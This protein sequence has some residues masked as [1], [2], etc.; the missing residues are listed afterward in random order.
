[1]TFSLK[2]RSLRA[3]SAIAAL[4]AFA[5]TAA[6]ADPD[7]NPLSPES[8]TYRT[9]NG[10]LIELTALAD[11]AV[12]V[13]YTPN[14][15]FSKKP[16]FILANAKPRAFTKVV[17]HDFGA[18]FT[19]TIGDL[20]VS[21]LVMAGGAANSRTPQKAWLAF[22]DTKKP[23][24]HFL[25][26]TLSVGTDAA[27]GAG[28]FDK[29]PS[30]DAP[31]DSYRVQ[32]SFSYGEKGF[33]FYGLGQ[34][35]DGT[36]DLA[37]LPRQ[38][39][40]VNT[41]ASVPFLVSPDGR[42]GIL[43]HNYSR[44]EFNPADTPIELKKVGEGQGQTVNVTTSV[45]GRREFR[46]D[47]TLTGEFTV[48]AD[49]EYA[50]QLDCGQT[51]ARRHVVSI[52]GKSI[53][54]Q[55]NTWLPPVIGF[56]V[57]LT[58]GKH[59][60]T[61][62]NEAN[63]RT[64]LKYGKC[65]RTRLTFRSDDAKE[66]DYVVITG[67]AEKVMKTYRELC[68]RTPMLPKYA[69]GYWHC[70]ERYVSQADL[71][72]NLREFRARKI[73]VDIIVQ[74]WQWWDSGKWNS[75]HFD[76]Q[77]FA[78][79]KG[80]NDEVHAL[81][82]H[83]MLSVWS[84]AS[85]DNPFAEKMI[86]LD[87]YIKGTDW[88]DF[89]KPAAAKLYWDTIVSDILS[90][91]IDSWWFDATEPEN[92]DLHN[93][94][95]TLGRGNEYRNVYP[96]IVNTTAY[97]RLREAQPDRRALILTRCA[98]AGQ[99]RQPSVIWSG[100]VG[101]SWSDFRTQIISGLGMMMSG[102]PYWTTD[103]GGFFR[104]GDQYRNREYIER[105]LRWFEYSTFAPILRVHGYTSQTELWRYGAEAEKVFRKYLDI[106][107]RLL[108]YIYTAAA[109]AALDGGVMMRPWAV[110]FPDISSRIVTEQN[111]TEYML[112]PSL[113]VAPITAST[114][115][116][117]VYLPDNGKGWYDLWT[118]EH[119]TGNS[120]ATVDA[121]LDRIP[122]FVKAGAIL[123]WGEPMQ[124]VDEKLPETLEI[125]VYPGADGSYSLYEDN[126]KDYSYEQGKFT[127]I[128]F[129]WDD[130]KGELTIGDRVGEYDGMLKDRTFR[131]CLMNEQNAGA[132]NIAK[133]DAEVKYS[134]RKLSVQL[135]SGK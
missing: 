55:R 84:K 108:P 51:M 63:D 42:F 15:A 120:V 11:N 105:M 93:R 112:G 25:D 48:D 18:E 118:G 117:D 56:K 30:R 77:R 126:G 1:M 83:S 70:R 130:A 115:K 94:T 87:G 121:P 72:S 38:L 47:S 35:Q 32:T 53:V 132:D 3:F 71:L 45:G 128:P 86:A 19:C 114:A 89:T 16:E 10:L 64:T 36:L 110:D 122:V 91:G 103:T 76:P 17:G 23:E 116:A 95:I 27:A 111:E 40:Q 67:G 79:P 52:D 24:G 46:R 66:I 134:G 9:D 29:S 82:A 78:D 100:D 49:G 4:S 135:K 21:Y 127:R 133:P 50:F 80:M 8:F 113:L 99:S 33:R 14:K 123:P 107:Y 104:P 58:A 88:I 124:Y 6:A 69:F 59:T 12:R 125:R 54:E 57:E 98:F 74:D 7:T 61:V 34:F 60:V 20:K 22:F 92:D 73:P 37:G 13:R 96:L 106:R 65:N 68:G 43:W 62:Q 31:A 101:N 26:E 44:T 39:L 90:T 81:N 5:L 97:D 129:A 131:V 75:M 109:D 28:K 102:I 85:K 119:Y 41:Q 2:L